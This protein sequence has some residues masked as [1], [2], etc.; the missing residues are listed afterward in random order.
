MGL[1]TKAGV[2]V[3]GTDACVDVIK[4]KKA[5]LVIIANDAAIRTKKNFE[6]LCQDF[7]VPMYI[8]GETEE[9]SKAIGKSN[10][11]VIAIKN[12]NFAEQIIKM[13]NGGE[14]IG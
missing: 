6:L 8:W 10:K 1:S 14:I 13:I 5:K 7:E 11:V 9:I 3:F 4:R 2:L 12:K